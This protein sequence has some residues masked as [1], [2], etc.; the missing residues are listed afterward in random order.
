MIK[1]EW[2]EGSKSAHEEVIIMMDMKPDRLRS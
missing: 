1:T 2:G